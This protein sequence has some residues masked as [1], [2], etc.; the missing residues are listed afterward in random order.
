MRK[1]ELQ[2]ADHAMHG[3]LNDCARELERLSR[4]FSLTGNSRV[5]EHLG[6]I[7]RDIAEASATISSNSSERIHL[8]LREA[9]QA[10]ANIL[11]TALAAATT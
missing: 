7:A 5:S 6:Q 9:E 10:S 8:D 3:L 2:E 11:K 4:A 1:D